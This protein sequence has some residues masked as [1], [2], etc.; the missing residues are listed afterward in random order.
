MGGRGR[1]WAGV[2][3]V[4]VAAGGLAAC[5]DDDEEAGGPTGAGAGTV[6]I[7]LRE[8]AFGVGGPLTAGGTLRVR[9]SGREF[10]MIGIGKLRS[11]KSLADFRAA[12]EE[13]M[14]GGDEGALDAVAEE[15]SQPGLIVGPGST[16]EVTAPGFGAGRYALVCF[17]NVEGE[18]T[19]HAA[20]GMIAALDVVAGKAPMP[21]PDATY[22]GRKGRAVAGPTSLKAGRHVLAIEAAGE[23]AGDLEPGL[24]KLNPGVTP[25][26]FVKAT[27]ELVSGPLPKG[28]A[29]K[30]PGALLA[31]PFDFGSARRVYL[32]LDL[33]PGRYLLAVRDTDV[34]SQAGVP[35]EHVV[36]TV[37]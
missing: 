27:N 12:L 20:R 34:A 15:Q 23:G 21:R 36:I 35:V 19:P 11:G 9:N 37:T 1:W 24:V 4:L 33:G 25:E 8:Y 7:D 6:D 13:V 32:A 30:M 10:H 17:L 5:G 2:L 22:V 16:V 26:Q 28:A 3:A 18:E 29:A 31:D 14:S